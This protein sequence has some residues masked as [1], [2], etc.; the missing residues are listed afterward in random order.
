MAYSAAQH[1]GHR[2][3]HSSL[4]LPMLFGSED[5]R[6]RTQQTQPTP[7]RSHAM[8]FHGQDVLHEVLDLLLRQF[9]VWHLGIGKL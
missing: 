6:W 7:L 9:L 2:L 3:S 1:K 8:L 5:I 4:A